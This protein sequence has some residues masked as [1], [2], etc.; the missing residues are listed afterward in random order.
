M[1]VLWRD[2]GVPWLHAWV[3]QAGRGF[4]SGET[5][6]K[7]LYTL[8]FRTLVLKSLLTGLCGHLLGPHSTF[9]YKTFPSLQK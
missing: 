4:S 9:S 7:L 8:L 3:H 5:G 1:E 2:Q 6:S